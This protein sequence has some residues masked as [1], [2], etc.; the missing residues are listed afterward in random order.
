[1]AYWVALL[2]VPKISALGQTPA[3][4]ARPAVTGTYFV[5][6]RGMAMLS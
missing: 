6:Y 4:P 1:M 3:N 5:Y 2:F